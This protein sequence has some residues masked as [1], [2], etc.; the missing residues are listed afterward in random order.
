VND[1]ARECQPPCPFYGGC[2]NRLSEGQISQQGT[3]CVPVV[4]KLY[5]LLHETL[6]AAK[7]G[8]PARGWIALRSRA[9]ANAI[10]DE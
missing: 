8:L 9:I 5:F 7:N 1:P 6:F 2:F 3:P 4:S 10:C